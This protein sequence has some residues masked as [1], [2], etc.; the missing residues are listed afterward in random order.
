[1]PD[2]V[3]EYLKFAAKTVIILIIFYALKARQ[4]AIKIRVPLLYT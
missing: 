2:L 1:M 4:T 3:P